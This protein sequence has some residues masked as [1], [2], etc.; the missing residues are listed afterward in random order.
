[1]DD[2]LDEG[3]RIEFSRSHELRIDGDVS[4][5]GIKMSTRVRED[6]RVEDTLTRLRNGLEEAMDTEIDKIV[7][8]V[9]KKG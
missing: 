8:Y 4:W 3:D 2:F 6:E 7:E 1:M 9:R 5:V